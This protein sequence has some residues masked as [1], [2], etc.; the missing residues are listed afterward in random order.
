N[1]RATRYRCREELDR[2]EPAEVVEHHRP[3]L[4]GQVPQLL[5][6]LIEDLLALLDLGCGR[7][8]LARQRCELQ[9]HGH[10]Q[11]PRIVV[12]GVSD[13]ANL[14]LEHLV[15]V[16]P[17][18]QRVA[19]APMGHLEIGRASCRKEGRTRVWAYE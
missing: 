5:L 7:G 6:G 9:V 13:A 3:Q 15:D 12:Q 4:M 18:D 16:P 10:Q 8:Y 14:L 11:L 2:G 19:I 17:G 1:A